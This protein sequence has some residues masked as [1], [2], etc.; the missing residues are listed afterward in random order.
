VIK[1]VNVA[2]GSGADA[3]VSPDLGRFALAAQRPSGATAAPAKVFSWHI[4]VIVGQI[5]D[6]RTAVAPP[7]ITR[8]EFLPARCQLREEDAFAFRTEVWTFLYTLIVIRQ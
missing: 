3:R 7:A 1:L 5:V 8:A 4:P 6:R 2:V